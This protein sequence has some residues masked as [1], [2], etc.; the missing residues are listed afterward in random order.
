MGVDFTQR[1][2]PRWAALTWLAVGLLALMAVS[3]CRKG[4]PAI[5]VARKPVEASGTIS[6]TINGPQGTSVVEGRLVQAI[7]V[8]TGER[9]KATT[10]TSGGFTFKVPPGRYRVELTLREGESLVKQPGVLE[11]NR[12]DAD[13]NADFIVGSARIS[14]PHHGH[15]ADDGL[16]APIA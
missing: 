10:N 9:Q 1:Y 14:R 5:D 7:N 8:A 4:T 11:L 3:A 6:G 15:R 12:S 16:G 2:W 13:A